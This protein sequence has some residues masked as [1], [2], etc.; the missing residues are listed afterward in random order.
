MLKTTLLS[1][2]LF[3]I[4]STSALANPATVPIDQAFSQT[5]HLKISANADHFLDFSGTGYRVIGAIPSNPQ[6]LRAV[7][8]SRQNDQE[9][10]L[11]WT[12]NGSAPTASIGVNVRGPS[13]TEKTIP[14]LVKRSGKSD[15]IRTAF[16]P[17]QPDS[18]DSGTEDVAQ[19]PTQSP[20]TEA[21]LI[22]PNWKTQNPPQK[23]QPVKPP[24]TANTSTPPP[25]KLRRTPK[26]VPRVARVS[27]TGRTLIDRSSLDKNA[28]ANYLLR[29]LHR[30]R[31]RR[32]INR[33][34]DNYWRT[35]SMARYLKRGVPI[36]KALRWSKLPEKTYNDLLGHGGV[37]P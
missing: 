33:H 10:I 14:F 20:P 16:V 9:L 22:R 15:N 18:Q 36:D 1:A 25:V 31:G 34:H 24:L 4:T 17:S 6:Q 19:A 26:P 13:G 27:A 32:E 23:A 12:P 3:A 7:L 35:Q 21:D 29:G 8:L 5:H 28:L 30:A 11:R 37:S 2:G